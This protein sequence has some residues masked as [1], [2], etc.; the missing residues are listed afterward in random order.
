MKKVMNEK[1]ERGW[2]ELYWGA[3]SA[4][5]VTGVE[6]GEVAAMSPRFLVWDLGG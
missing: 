1:E 3:G 5:L 6:W 2:F 4:G